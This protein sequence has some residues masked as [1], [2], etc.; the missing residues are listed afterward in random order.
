[1]SH[2]RAVL[3]SALLVLIGLVV[4][5]ANAA[6]PDPDRP[7]VEEQ[8][9]VKRLNSYAEGANICIDA[10]NLLGLAPGRYVCRGG[11]WESRPLPACEKVSASSR[12][13]QNLPTPSSSAPPASAPPPN[14]PGAGS[15]SPGSSTPV[16][17]ACKI[18]GT[19]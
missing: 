11:Q 1:M 2:V 4:T 8:G 15:G 18:T 10:G 16:P 3:A 14:E 7:A 12:P 13:K 17:G 6:C 5:S 19:C 9:I